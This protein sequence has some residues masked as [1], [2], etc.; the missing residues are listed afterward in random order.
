MSGIGIGI[1]LGIVLVIV[2]VIGRRGW[3]RRWGGW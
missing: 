3:L 1:V 2:I